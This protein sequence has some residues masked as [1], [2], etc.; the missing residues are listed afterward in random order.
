MRSYLEI[1][2]IRFQD[3]LTVV[4]EVSAECQEAW[5]PALLLLPLVENAIRHGLAPQPGPGRITVEAQREGACLRLA[6]TDDGPGSPWPIQEHVGL[7]GT[8]QRLELLYGDRAALLLESPG[9][10]GFRAV[11]SL[12]LAVRPC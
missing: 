2:G 9:Q 8:R 5:L 6:V 11:I 7:G 3:R 4:L 1:E 10:Q 12:P